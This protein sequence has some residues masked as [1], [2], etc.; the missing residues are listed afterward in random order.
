M[1]KRLSLLLTLLLLGGCAGSS[2]FQPYPNRIASVQTQLANGNGG[3]AIQQLESG[4]SG[5]DSLLYAQEAGRVAALSGDLDASIRFYQMAMTDYDQ[6]DWKAIVSLTDISAQVGG[7]TVSDNLIPYHGQAFERVMLHQQQ[8]LNYLWQGQYE[9]AMVEVRRADQAQQKAQEAYRAAL[10]SQR[11]I[12]NAAIDEQLTELDRQAGNAP[13]SFINPYVLFS[14]AVLY[15]AG[16]QANDALIDIRKALQLIPENRLLQR[17][18]VRLSCQVG[19]DCD[20]LSKRYGKVERPGADQ[21][22]LVVLYETGTL[23]AKQSFWVPFSWDGLYQ[24][25]ALPTYRDNRPAPAPL[26]LNIADT[27]VTTEPLANL[28]QMAAR[29]LREQ[30][31]FILVRQGIRLTAKHN[32]NRW[33]ERQGGELGAFSMQVLNALTEQA[34]RRSWLTLPRQAQGWA[35]FVPAG[36]HQL[37]LDGQAHTLAT[38]PGR[39]TLVWIVRQGSS[40]QIRSTLI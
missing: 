40:R 15:E 18:L 37:T 30:Y 24:Q 38:A 25:I 4:L 33:A 35:G 6:Y 14:N 28:D 21:A 8:S 27:R 20:D 36:E 17:E 5:A 11:A 16:G 39:T 29:S 2:L 12:S 3:K 10:K 34:D 22:R 31:P 23:P 19:I 1:A 7:A 13:D 9:G 32:T 26:T